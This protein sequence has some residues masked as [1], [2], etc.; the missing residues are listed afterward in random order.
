[1][2]TLGVFAQNKNW[3]VRTLVGEGTG[4]AAVVIDTTQPVEAETA[5]RCHVF[6]ARPE[7]YHDSHVQVQGH[8]AFR[9]LEGVGVWTRR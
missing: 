8:F 3:T 6:S 9:C 2:A 1:M 4:N 7:D 5:Q